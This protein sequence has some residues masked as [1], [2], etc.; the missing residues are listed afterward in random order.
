MGFVIR[1]ALEML[2]KQLP[3]HI[4]N[5]KFMDMGV[6]QLSRY[7]RENE[8][9]RREVKKWVKDIHMWAIDPKNNE[10]HRWTKKI[11]KNFEERIAAGETEEE[12]YDWYYTHHLLT[13]LVET[14]SLT[15]ILAV[16]LGR[17]YTLLP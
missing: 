3:P 17:I 16:F 5:S 15:I 12:I 2:R 13:S 11:A 8:K 6:P 9:N 4:L 14:I 7:A 1:G 10:A